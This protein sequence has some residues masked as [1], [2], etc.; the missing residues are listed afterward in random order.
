[1][2]EWVYNYVILTSVL[3]GSVSAV[4][5][6][7]LSVSV[8]KVPGTRWIGGCVGSRTGLD[9][10]EKRKLPRVEPLFCDLATSNLFIVLPDVPMM[11]CECKK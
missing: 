10:V 3:F 8:Q 6:P 2:E 4:S 5:R 11:K 1:M 9:A 7:G